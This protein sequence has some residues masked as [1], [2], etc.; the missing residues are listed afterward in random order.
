MA[1]SVVTKSIGTAGR[2]FTTVALWEAAQDD[3]DLN[4]GDGRTEIGLMH[5]DSD[6]TETGTAL[7]FTG[8]DLQNRYILAA[9]PG[10]EYKGTEGSGVLWKPTSG[11][12]VMLSAGAGA[13]ICGIEFD[14]S[15]GWTPVNEAI[16]QASGP[17]ISSIAYGCCF[18]DN[19]S[20]PGY[21]ITNTDFPSVIY[22]LSYNN[23]SDGFNIVVTSRKWLDIQLCGAFGNGGFGA[24]ARDLATI[25]NRA[26]GSWFFNNTS[27]S[28]DSPD[29]AA[30]KNNGFCIFDDQPIT[31]AGA[32]AVWPG[33]LENQ[34]LAN[35]NFVGSGTGDF[36]LQAGSIALQTGPPIYF[37]NTNKSRMQDGFHN[38]L[39]PDFGKR[40]DVGPHQ[41]SL[42][43]AAAVGGRQARARYHNV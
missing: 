22:C 35:M 14:G 42:L 12:E 13:I 32:G 43:V 17:L 30:D 3:T 31:D 11:S 25:G 38:V 28:L 8:V 7:T 21:Q 36:N 33:I 26:Q 24:R 19:P 2:D 9:A 29:T 5:A 10:D 40:F 23:S 15:G 16:C 20:G 37:Y 27:G 41:F 4:S 1:Y 34:I 6:F 18:H 39:D